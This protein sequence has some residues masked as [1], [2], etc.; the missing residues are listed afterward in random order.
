MPTLSKSVCTAAALAVACAYAGAGIAQPSPKAYPAKPV[1]IVIPLGPGNS[2]EI[3]MRLVAEKLSSAL[4]QPFVIEAQ[5]GAA[6]QIGAER[7]AKSPAD[8]YTLLAATDGVITMLPN[9]QKHVPFDPIRDF[10][11][12]VEM[13]GIPFVLI[14]HP[15]VPARTAEE[16]VRLAKA[17]PG[18]LEFSSGGTGSS[19]QLAMELFMGLTGTKLVHVPYKGA[20]QAAMDVVSGQIPVALAGVP[21]VAALIK[22]GRLRALG[23]A[24]DRRLPLLAEVPTL[25]EQGIPLRFSTWGGLFAPSGTPVEVIRTLNHETVVALNSA[26]VR[27]RMSE[28]GFEVY[29]NSSEEFSEMVKADFAKMAK[30]IRQAGIEPQ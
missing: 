20:P 10:S 16:L 15:S 4:G 26:D 30:V 27:A 3:A 23:I 12:I 29:G 24:S 17:Q 9:L 19:Q 18:K 22:Q 21:I 13:I 28:L 25:A 8:G 6:G 14:V 1:K 11:P 7:V 2:L 5:P